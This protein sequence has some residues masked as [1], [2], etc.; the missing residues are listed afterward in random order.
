MV[1]DSR[2]PDGHSG[3]ICP[4]VRAVFEKQVFFGWIWYKELL[5]D[6]VNLFQLSDQSDEDPDPGYWYMLSSMIQWQIQSVLVYDF[7]IAT[8]M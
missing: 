4:P 1:G 6:E 8:L 7:I 2:S 3:G 5:A